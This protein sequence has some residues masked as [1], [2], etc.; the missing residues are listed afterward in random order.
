MGNWWYYSSG[1]KALKNKFLFIWTNPRVNWPTGRLFFRRENN[2][3]QPIKWMCLFGKGWIGCF[4]QSHDGKKKGSAF[5]SKFQS[6]LLWSWRSTSTRKNLKP[7]LKIKK[8]VEN[9]ISTTCENDTN[10]LFFQ[11][12]LSVGPEPPA[13]GKWRPR[14]DVTLFNSGASVLFPTRRSI[15]NNVPLFRPCPFKH[16]S[17]RRARPWPR[18]KSPRRRL[19]PLP[20]QLQPKKSLRPLPSPS[21]PPHR[22]RLPTGPRKSPLSSRTWSLTWG[23]RVAPT[24]RSSTPPEGSPAWCS[25]DE[26]VHRTTPPCSSLP[27]YNCSLIPTANR[28]HLHLGRGFSILSSPSDTS[29]V[30]SHTLS[31]IKSAAIQSPTSCQSRGLQTIT[32]NG[33]PFHVCLFCFF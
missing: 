27:P 12:N 11:D 18:R 4:P 14:T 32:L 29:P 17:P 26:P 6:W 31:W 19:L 33:T 7:F 21:R 20:L 13:P 30:P 23:R 22:P 3:L 9:Y 2:L 15:F 24:T 1:A 10:C 25:T 5:K 16:P 28:H 8:V